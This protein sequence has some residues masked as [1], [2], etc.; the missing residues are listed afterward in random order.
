ITKCYETVPPIPPPLGTNPS[1]AGSHN[2]VHTILNDNTTN[3]GTNNVTPNVDVDED[4]PQ[5]L[6]TK[7]GSHVTNVPEFDVE[8]FTS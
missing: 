1:N 8:N 4:L 6:D 7:R 3:T 5:L 2:R